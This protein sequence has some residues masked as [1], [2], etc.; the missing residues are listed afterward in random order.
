MDHIA[1]TKNY[2]NIQTIA[3]IYLDG[4]PCKKQI[5]EIVKYV[6]H[7]YNKLNT[8]KYEDHYS[9]IYNEITEEDI[10]KEISNFNEKLWE[11]YIFIPD[12][13]QNKSKL[14]IKC[15]HIIFDGASLVYLINQISLFSNSMNLNS[16]KEKK[17]KQ[18]YSIN[19][20]KIC[21]NNY[22][23]VDFSLGN[24]DDLKKISKF[25]NT[26]LNNIFISILADS[27]N[28]DIRQKLYMCSAI[29]L[30]NPENNSLKNNISM[31]K[32][33]CPYKNNIVSTI[34][35]VTK[36]MNFLKKCHKN[37]FLTLDDILLYSGYLLGFEFIADLLCISDYF[38]YK[39]NPFICISNLII[40]NNLLSF[41]NCNIMD[42]SITTNS[43]Q[44]TNIN[45]IIFY[46]YLNNIKI[47]L[48]YNKKYNYGLNKKS[49]LNSSRKLWNNLSFY[50]DLK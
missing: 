25:Y 8:L 50:T 45:Y 16:K 42:F 4:I 34:Y 40:S 7:N 15:S 49:I 48:S 28:S 22:K 39:N 2:S 19:D 30:K 27:C 1:K 36:K 6:Y 9:F 13:K 37:N 43:I 11:I 18:K 26:T 38:L 31:I 29:T 44:Y 3:I 21:N 33:K 12:L 17:Y 20:K 14:L 5:H 10:Y 23:F 47:S 46:T 24:V 32:Y 35:Y 41:A